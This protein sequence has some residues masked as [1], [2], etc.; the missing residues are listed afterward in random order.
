[1]DLPEENLKKLGITSRELEMA[2][3]LI[4]GMVDEWKPEKYRD[5]YRKDLLSLIHAR[6]KAGD[7]NTVTKESKKAAKPE[8]SAK[9]VDL[10]ALLAE[11]VAS[12][13]PAR[14]RKPASRGHSNGH[15]QARAEHSSGSHKK[16]A[17][18]KHRETHAPHRKS[19]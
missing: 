4:S 2:E 5:D 10:V 3:K 11:S 17:P 13:H 16:H 6:A 7:V 18:R 8:K 14:A 9:V 12:P 15:A 1:L 19:A